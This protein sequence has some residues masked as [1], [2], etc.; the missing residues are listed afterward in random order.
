MVN[1]KKSASAENNNSLTLLKCVL[2]NWIDQDCIC[3]ALSGG[4]DSIVLLHI[5]HEANKY[6]RFELTSMHVN[7]NLSPHAR[8][9]ATFCQRLCDR[10]NVPLQ[11]VNV[12]IKKNGGESLENQMRIAR[13]K[14]LAN[15]TAKVI[16]L[17]HHQNDQIETTLSQ[18][19]RG[20]SLHNIAS[21]KTISQKNNKLLW[22]PLLNINRSQIEG[23]AKENGLNYVTDESNF[24]TKFLRNFIRHKVLPLL[25]KWDANIAT[26]LLNFNRQL[27]DLLMLTDQIGQNDC[28]F[29]RVSHKCLDVEK[30]RQ[31]SAIR[32]LNLLT[33]FIQNHKLP[34]P[35]N[36]QIKEF[37]A[38]ASSSQWDKHPKLYIIDDIYL[39]KYKNTICLQ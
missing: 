18:L 17:A 11:V 26:K 21:M 28:K 32:Q 10:L 19:L 15:T 35:S 3:V 7:H 12:N 14:E 1:L 36:K 24:D 33:I 25:N 9:W 8:N 29:C 2:D 5:L 4:V 38:Q 31:L 37:A 6:H 22:R 16:A 30:F 13:Y 34:L 39:L 23:Y 20:S 27:Q